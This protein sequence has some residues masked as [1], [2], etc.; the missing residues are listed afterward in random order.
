MVLLVPL[1][2]FLAA[3]GAA[4][5]LSDTIDREYV[6]PV[7][8]QLQ[9]ALDGREPNWTPPVLPGTAQAAKLSGEVR[10][11]WLE[12]LMGAD[13]SYAF[14]A[15]RSLASAQAFEPPAEPDL[16]SI[17]PGVSLSPATED[18]VTTVERR[19]MSR[20]FPE[21]YALGAAGALGSGR[22]D[23]G[24]S[25][26]DLSDL[27]QLPGDGAAPASPAARPRFARPSDFARPRKFADSTRLA[28]GPAG[29]AGASA[30]PKLKP[31][32]SR[33]TK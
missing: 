11:L 14:D 5:T 27:T 13:Q 31:F 19:F 21:D 24:P 30:P 8:Q 1:A 4:E 32:R 22:D 33:L 7:L 25:A 17:L 6:Q 29:A 15:A 18:L 12:P 26:P 23:D 3:P 20:L 10:L 16:A 2:L 9:G 28:H